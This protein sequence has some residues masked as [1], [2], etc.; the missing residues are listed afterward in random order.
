MH[1]MR[2]SR[3]LSLCAGTIVVIS[4]ASLSFTLS[5]RLSSYFYAPRKNFANESSSLRCFIPLSL[6]GKKF[7]WGRGE[8]GA[9]KAGKKFGGTQFR[10]Y[11]MGYFGIRDHADQMLRNVSVEISIVIGRNIRSNWTEFSTCVFKMSFAS[12]NPL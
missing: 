9:L 11:R 7:D 1:A 2:M 12:S 5:L 6:L 10:L 4:H 3:S 8:G